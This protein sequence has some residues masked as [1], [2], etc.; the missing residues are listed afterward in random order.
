MKVVG[1]HH[2][3]APPSPLFTAYRTIP[4]IMPAPKSSGLR[5]CP[6]LRLWKTETMPSLRPDGSAVRL[7]GGD[8]PRGRARRER[9]MP[10]RAFAVDAQAGSEARVSETRSQRRRLRLTGVVA[11][12]S[13]GYTCQYVRSPARALNASRAPGP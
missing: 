5:A 6:G 12:G 7:S 3:A 1:N 9:R 2:R 8:G 10:E 13:V 4:Q 11:I